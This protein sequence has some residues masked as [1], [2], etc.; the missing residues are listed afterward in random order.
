MLL[1]AWSFHLAGT[2]FSNMSGGSTTWSS[3]LTMI[4]SSI[5]IRLPRIQG[6]SSAACELV[7]T[8]RSPRPHLGNH[9]RAEK[10]QRRFGIDVG[11]GSVDGREADLVQPPQFSHQA[12]HT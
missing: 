4:M 5:F 9:L 1:G 10:L 6:R 11:D 7:Q 3:M 2:C 12:V 8:A